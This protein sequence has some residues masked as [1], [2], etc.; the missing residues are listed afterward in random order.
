MRD[1]R[2]FEKKLLTFATRKNAKIACVCFVFSF[3]YTGIIIVDQK[4]IQDTARA[5]II[6]L[7][8]VI[9]K[10]AEYPFISAVLGEKSMSFPI[11]AQAAI[12]MDNDSKVIL[13]AKNEN[14]RFSMA[15]TAKIMTALVAIEHFKSSD[16]LI[17]QNEKVE[18][19]NVGFTKGEKVYFKDLLYAMLLPS[20]NDAAIA[21]AQNYPGGEA[22]F[23]EKMNEKAK[24]LH[25]F[26]THYTDASGLDDN[27]NYTTVLDLARLASFGLKNE[28]LSSIVAT[29]K[30]VIRSLD[31]NVYI[32]NN[33]NKLLGIDGVY[34]MKTGHT[35]GA[36]DV[37]VTIKKEGEKAFILVVMK[38]QDRFADTQTLL[39]L[40]SGQMQYQS[41]H[42]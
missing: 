15:S 4:I 23:V 38:S 10:P 2:A 20:G 32:L 34:G 42:P 36:G 24:D 25:L 7:P 37:L 11:T 19:V 27:G 29:K 35:E 39:S 18:G 40:I 14:F 33:L 30:Y 21:I 16:I 12:I 8:F 41:M 3:L 1:Y 13:Y 17:V 26:K 6:P 9:S 31:G 5:K 28:T 22:V